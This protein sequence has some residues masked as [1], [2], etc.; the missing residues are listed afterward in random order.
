MKR[1]F[2]SFMLILMAVS[3]SVSALVLESPRASL[4]L[5]RYFAEC[6]T[7]DSKGEIIVSY[8]V[9]ASKL[10]SSVGVKSI[11]FYTRDGDKVSTVSGSVQ[12]GLVKT[13]NDDHMGDFVYELP[14]GEYYYAEVTAFAQVGSDYDSRTVTTS[15]VWVR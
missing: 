12:N 1:I 8:D 5:S 13:N 15:N 7:G 11:V 2:A 9:K 10:A 3:C 4:T 14:S 6:L